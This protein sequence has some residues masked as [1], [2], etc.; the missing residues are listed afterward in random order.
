[1][2]RRVRERFPTVERVTT[3]GRAS[4][5]AR[6]APDHLALLQEAGLT[7]LHLGLE[8]GADE[9][10]QAVDKG[11]SSGELIAAGRRCWAPASSCAST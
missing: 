9:V 8:S 2:I 3:N 10:L 5:L 4:T 11:C 1:M 6:R 7:R